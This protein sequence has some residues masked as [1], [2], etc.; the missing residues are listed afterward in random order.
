MLSVRW[1]AV[2]V[3]YVV[4]SPAAALM[5]IMLAKSKIIRNASL[6]Y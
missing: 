3:S 4:A 1:D 6:C 5:G 2:L